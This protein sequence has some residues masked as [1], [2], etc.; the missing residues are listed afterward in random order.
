MRVLLCV[1]VTS[2]YIRNLNINYQISAV[3]VVIY[4]RRILILIFEP[5]IRYYYIIIYYRGVRFYNSDIRGVII[6]TL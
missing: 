1:P 5:F 3:V 4:C 6:D 2:R